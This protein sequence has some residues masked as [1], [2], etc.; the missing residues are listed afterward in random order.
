MINFIKKY[1]IALIACAIAVVVLAVAFVFGGNSANKSS[2]T[3]DSTQSVTASTETVTTSETTVNTT[4]GTTVQPTTDNSASTTQPVTEK[5][6][7]NTVKQ[8]NKTEVKEQQNSAETQPATDKYKTEP[9]PQG[10]PKPVEPQEQTV[11]DDKIYCTFS[12]SCAKILES[13]EVIDDSI[14]DVVPKDG[15]IYKPQKI[16]INEGESVFDILLRVCRDNN[17]HTEF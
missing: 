13:P 15:W 12:I 17:I 3:P 5:P 4:V 8:N 9:V 7:Q 16:E 11:S 2:E 1:K 6:N 10:K 14:A